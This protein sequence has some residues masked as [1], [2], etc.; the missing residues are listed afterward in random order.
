[1]IN[2]KEQ[3]AVYRLW[4]SFTT[5]NLP[6]EQA[7]EACA[8]QHPKHRSEWL[9][10][11]AQLRNGE[12][13]SDALKASKLLPDN[14]LSAIEAGEASSKLPNIF[15]SLMV[16]TEQ[17]DRLRSQA[18]SKLAQ[19]IIYCV[20]A[21]SFLYI[22]MIVM[23]PTM[24]AGAGGPNGRGELLEMLDGLRGFFVV[25]GGPVLAL[26]VGLGVMLVASRSIDAVGEQVDTALDRVP[27]WGE[28]NRLLSSALWSRLFALLDSAGTMSDDAAMQIATRALKK[29]HQEP[30]KKLLADYRR[31][32]SLSQASNRKRWSR[33]DP[34]T[35]WSILFSTTLY[36]GASTG[37]LSE[38]LPEAA[39]GLSEEGEAAIMAAV[40]RANLVG[41]I[42]AG[43]SIGA[44]MVMMIMSSLATTMAAL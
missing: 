30:Y 9:K 20:G 35:S 37:T 6:S 1:M 19:P 39:A 5:A 14:A 21:L 3:I 38:T 36:S 32:G 42:V 27:L 7:A 12:R 10:V 8:E 24:T 34:R 41:L 29:V 28:G 44:I 17:D 18:R 13:L 40:A 15:N 23:F 22:F 4:K 33:A 11:R 2:A 25:T 16:M 43:S 26:F 31:S